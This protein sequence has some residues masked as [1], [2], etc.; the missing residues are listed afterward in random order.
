LTVSDIKRD[1]DLRKAGVIILLILW[2]ILTHYSVHVLKVARDAVG[3]PASQAMVQT[4]VCIVVAAL[5]I[6]IRDIYGVVYVFDMKDAKLNPITG[7]LWVK[8][9]FIVLVQLSAVLAL[10]ASG[11]ISRNKAPTLSA[12]RDT[13][14]PFRTDK[15]L[16]GISTNEVTSRG[17]AESV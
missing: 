1:D 14:T 12:S 17:E 9:I 4:L 10:A 11:W 13:N 5:F 16:I 7:S 8:V 3:F 6:G 2:I 15:G